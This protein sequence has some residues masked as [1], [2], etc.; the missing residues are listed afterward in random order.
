MT[1]LSV[2]VDAVF[3]FPPASLAMA[4]GIVAVTVPDFVIPDTE[5]VY[6]VG[7]PVTTLVVAPAVP[8]RT[9][10][11]ELNP[12]TASLNVAVNKTG[13]LAAGSI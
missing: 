3:G 5:M 8:P 11:A 12:V 4:A 10:S 7:P 1:V 2:L 13:E 6:T 9:T